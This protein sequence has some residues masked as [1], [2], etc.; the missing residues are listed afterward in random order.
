MRTTNQEK[1]GPGK[2]TC[3]V[4]KKRTGLLFLKTG[5]RDI[6]TANNRGWNIIA[7]FGHY[8]AMRFI[9]GDAAVRIVFPHQQRHEKGS[10]R[11]SY[12]RSR[13]V[14]YIAAGWFVILF[15]SSHETQHTESR[16]ERERDWR[17]IIT[18]IIKNNVWHTRRY[19]SQSIPLLADISRDFSIPVSSCSWNIFL[20]FI[21]STAIT[22][23]FCRVKRT[24]A[25]GFTYKLRDELHSEWQL[26]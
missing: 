24:I 16:R 26:E 22:R 3:R 1:V 6:R 11:I 17:L 10:F 4:K 2:D 14:N 18:I 13:L 15:S 5:I 8:K 20:L 19:I 25:S 21:F 7:P 23:D 12:G 9:A